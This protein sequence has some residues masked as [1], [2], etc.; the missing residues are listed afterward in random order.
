MIRYLINCILLA[1]P[2]TKF[3]AIRS[4]FLQLAGVKI[5]KKVKFCGHSWIYGRGKLS[6]GD[7][8][9]ISHNCRIYTHVNADVSIG[10]NC[11]IGPHVKLI[12][13]SHEI[14]SS[15]RRAGKEIANSISIGAG[16]WI[17]SSS[18]LLDG[19]SIPN[20]SIVGAGSVVTSPFFRSNS[21]FVGCPATYKKSYPHEPKL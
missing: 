17:G 4:F 12:V 5:G 18:T 13:G 3:F 15:A 20:G 19:V 6:I 1:I 10:P 7:N 21:L 2:P 9:W 16:V 8:T 14:G 11:D